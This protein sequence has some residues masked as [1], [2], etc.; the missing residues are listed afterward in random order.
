MPRI[1]LL[2]CAASLMTL[3][4]CLSAAA[5]T[6]LRCRA[7]EGGTASFINPTPCYEHDR[8]LSEEN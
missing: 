5:D 7:H 1:L 3:L 2:A 8:A 6:K 4:G